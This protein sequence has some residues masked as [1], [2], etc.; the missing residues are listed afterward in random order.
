MVSFLTFFAANGFE[1]D[2]S[3]WRAHLERL[4]VKHAYNYDHT[5]DL[6]QPQQVMELQRLLIKQGDDIGDVD[7]K[8][9]SKTRAA[10]KKA[11]LK[12][13]MPADAWPTSELIEKLGGSRAASVSTAAPPTR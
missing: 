7:G 11:Q 13:G 3:A 10:I 6:I 5:S 4:R 12:V 9:G 8:V 1:K 2:Y